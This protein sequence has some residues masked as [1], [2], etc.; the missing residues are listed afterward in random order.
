[1]VK[2]TYGRA[3]SMIIYQKEDVVD[4][5]K[6]VF[7]H[8]AWKMGWKDPVPDM[9]LDV[10]IELV[11][12]C[13]LHCEACPIT[14]QKRE[15]S[16]LE[17]ETLKR[18]V[19]EAAEEGVFYFTICG[20]GE[21][22]LHPDC[23]RLLRYIRDKK[24][25]AKGIR[26]I[27]FMPSIMISNAMWTKTQLEQCIEN[28]PDLLSVS[29]AGLTDEE[30]TK[31]RSPINLDRFYDNLAAVYKN[32]KVKRD[33]DGGV[34][35]VIHV[36]THIYPW[37]M[38]QRVEEIE[39]FKNK[40]FEIADAVVIKATMLDLHYKDYSNFIG[41][42]Y[43]KLTASSYER[44]APCFET[45]RRLSINSNGDVWCGH[46]NSEDFGNL[47]GNVKK[48]SLREVWHG[49]LMNAFRKQVRAGLFDR[50]GCKSCGEEL[51]IDD[52]NRTP[53]EKPE[54]SIKFALPILN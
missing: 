2:I 34:S 1:M 26:S 51:R 49:N 46:H 23:F 39:K 30:I 10:Q 38:E 47:L 4:V 3:N 44:T 19:D 53:P 37:E 42:S 8:P 24:V 28:P 52:F 22:A 12:Q 6:L 13:N 48:M 43:V 54:G 18:I 33:V 7:D 35:P 14:H 20:I 32:R 27:P 45:S 9:P 15:V 36:S 25:V 11:N 16:H 21:A 31:R 17:W 40:W 50:P 29:L 5:S 41:S